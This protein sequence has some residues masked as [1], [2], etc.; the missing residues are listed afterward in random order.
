MF[1]S[2][3]SGHTS[4]TFTPGDADHI[5]LSGGGPAGVVLD[6]D[7]LYTLTRFNNSV[8]VVDLD[9]RHRGT[10]GLPRPLPVRDC[11]GRRSG[12]RYR[13]C[14]ASA[15]EAVEVAEDVTTRAEDVT[16]RA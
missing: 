9:E 7:R 16:T 10:D 4:G 1:W 5:V 11:A 12:S 13:R 3:L 15:G 6:E 8:V 14:L 2:L